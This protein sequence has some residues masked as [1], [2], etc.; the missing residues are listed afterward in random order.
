MALTT[1]LFLAVFMFCLLG[2]ILFHPLLGVVGYVLTYVVAPAGQWWGADLAVM[3]MRYSFFMAAAIALG[4]LV[5][6]RRLSFPGKLYTQEILF[7]LLIGWIFL[8][9]Y[10]GLPG[11]QGDN[12][13]IKLFKVFVF[14]WMLIRTIESQKGYEIFLWTLILTT[15][16]VG[17][18]A[19]GVSTAQFGRLDR[20]VG[21]SDFAEGNFLAAHFAMVLPFIGVFFLRGSKKQKFFLIVAAVL[22]V[23]GI[24]LCR[25]RGVFLALVMGVVSAIYLTP[26]IWRSKIFALVMIGLIGSFFLMDEGFIER[27][28]RINP[29][30]SEIEEQDDSAAGRIMAWQAAVEM[31]GDYPL[32]IGQGNFFYYVGDYQPAIPGKDTHNTY[33]RALAELGF[34]GLLMILAMIWNAFKILR[35]QRRRIET[36]SLPHDI[37]LHVY[38]QSVALVI[39]L[40]AGLFITE[41]YIEEFYWLLMFPVLLE[42]VVDRQIIVQGAADAKVLERTQDISGISAGE[43]KS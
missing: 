25:S 11:Y 20:G 22:M 29:S 34:P 17:F 2:S 38:G 24:V 40:T 35:T 18:D 5:Q 3:G 14:T 43:I 31:F 27:M 19:L 42:R 16:Y 36:L 13:A 28:A 33:L 21:G 15:A 9:T 6:Y 23:N 10:I 30:L 37:Q 41:T 1:L 26:K 32:G 8:S 7:L 39:F 4:I 12:Y